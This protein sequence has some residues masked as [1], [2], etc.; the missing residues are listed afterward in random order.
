MA[1]T[2]SVSNSKCYKLIS[3]KLFNEKNVSNKSLLRG[4]INCK[5]IPHPT[6]PGGGTGGNFG[7]LNE[8]PIVL[9]QIQ[10]VHHKICWIYLTHFFVPVRDG[11]ANDKVS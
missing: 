6:A 3:R 2:Y 11:V 7:I 10:L 1:D 9:M 5:K 4:Q 8:T